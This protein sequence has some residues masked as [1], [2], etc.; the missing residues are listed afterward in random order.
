MSAFKADRPVRSAGAGAV[1]PTADAEK[2]LA[3]ST[4]LLA[5]HNDR[6]KI[7]ASVSTGYAA[8][9]TQRAEVFEK[10]VARC[11]PRHAAAGARQPDARAS[12]PRSWIETRS[13]GP[14]PG[15]VATDRPAPLIARN[16]ATRFAICARRFDAGRCCR[17]AWPKGSTTSPTRLQYRAFIEQYV[18]AA[19]PWR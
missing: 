10:A 5:C 8:G 4:E 11:A 17:D 16:T 12:I 1:S 15:P 19:R 13:T 7:A 14:Q 3:T 6:A 9:G 18:N 2:K